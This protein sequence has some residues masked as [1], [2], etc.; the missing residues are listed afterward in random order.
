MKKTVKK[1]KVI[2]WQKWNYLPFHIKKNLLCSI[3]SK[4]SSDGGDFPRIIE[5]AWSF[6]KSFFFSHK[7]MQESYYFSP[8]LIHL[9]YR[10]AEDLSEYIETEDSN[11]FVLH[12]LEHIR[13]SVNDYI[14]K[15]SCVSY[16][17]LEEINL[18]ILLFIATKFLKNS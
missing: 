1:L 8:I 5:I 7:Y 4:I 14:Y 11:I 12:D 13:V 6:Y 3:I 10:Y 18:Y 17:L 9:S 2:F 16:E 15:V